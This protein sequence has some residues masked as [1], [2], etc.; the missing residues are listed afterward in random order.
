MNVGKCVNEDGFTLIEG[1]L[2]ITLTLI[3]AGVI[4]SLMFSS[5]RAITNALKSEKEQYRSLVID[6][7]VRSAAASVSV[8]YW[9]NSRLGLSLARNALS[10]TAM[11][12]KDRESI[13]AITPLLDAQ[14]R[15]RGINVVFRI[16]AK[17]YESNALF[18]S[19]PVLEVPW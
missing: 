13:V 17:E 9:E 2:A 6:A 5:L 10:R 7:A 12:P 8:P 3:Y 15:Q 16:G 1:I 11:T 14:G 19:T 18:A 4:S